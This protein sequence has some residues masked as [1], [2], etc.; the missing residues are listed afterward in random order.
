MMFHLDRNLFPNVS[1]DLVQIAQDLYFM[2]MSCAP[3]KKIIEAQ[4]LAERIAAMLTKLIR[5]PNQK[6]H[7]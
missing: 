3:I 6:M 1:E 5:S 7:R 2:G 4:D